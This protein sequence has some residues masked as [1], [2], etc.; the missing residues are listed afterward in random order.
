M[1]KFWAHASTPGHQ[2]K[3]LDMFILFSSVTGVVGNAGQANHAAA[4]AFLDQLAAHRRMLGLPGQ[5]IAWGAWSG[6]GEAE[7]QRERIERQLASTGA[8]WITPQQG[9]KAFDWLVRHDVTTPTVTT[10]DCLSFTEGLETP[11]P[12]FGTCLLRRRLKGGR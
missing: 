6:I 2:D 4:N 7:E 11:P 12:F 10:V 1:A 5:A 3:D 8:G 9:I